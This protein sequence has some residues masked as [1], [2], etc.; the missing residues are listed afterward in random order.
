MILCHQLSQ[1]VARDLQ[2]Q[3]KKDMQ[4]R[5]LYVFLIYDS[6]KTAQFCIDNT[7]GGAIINQKGGL[8]K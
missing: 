8:G 2:A 4:V 6:T 1:G 5:Y 7:R 3:D